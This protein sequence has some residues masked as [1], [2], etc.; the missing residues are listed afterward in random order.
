MKAIEL[1]IP[2][3]VPQPKYHIG[4]Q[5]KERGNKSSSTILIIGL[6]YAPPQSEWEP[7][8]HYSVLLLY[9][10]QPEGDIFFLY[11]PCLEPLEVEHVSA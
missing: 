2:A 10:Y 6:L 4:Q 3:G 1:S 7:G 8:W 11:E 9:S 5:V